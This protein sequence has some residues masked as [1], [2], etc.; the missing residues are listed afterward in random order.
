MKNTTVNIMKK[1]SFAVLFAAVL[2]LVGAQS[3]QA[4]TITPIRLEVAGDPGQ[5]LSEEMT[6]I[7]ERSTP[8]TYY[9]SYSNFVTQGE[10]GSP[11]FVDAKD[12]LGTWMSAPDTITLAPGQSKIVPITITIPKSAEP[13]GHFAAVFWGT[14]SPKDVK[15]AVSIG[16]KTGILILL[17][18]NGAVN[19]DGGILEFNTVNAQRFYTALPVNF[20][21]RFQNSGGDRIKPVGDVTIKN[22]I[23]LTSAKVPG[24]PVEGNILP[25]STRKFETVWQGGSGPT[26]LAAADQ[27]NFLNKVSYEW[28]NFGFGHYKA[29]ISLSYGVKNQVSTGSVGFWVIPWHLMIFVVIVAILIFFIARKLIRRYNKWVIKMA[30]AAIKKEEQKEGQQ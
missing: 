24:N 4:L 16:S 9:S 29:D 11:A 12:D 17:R 13:G 21:Y 18:V 8:E 20:F 14:Q 10:T 15:N 5:I 3:A 2:L 1:S 27:G 28:R 25:S 6:L 23:W 19:E 26:P 7:N 30:E 22:M